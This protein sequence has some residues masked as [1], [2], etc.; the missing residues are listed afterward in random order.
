MT[1]TQY[2]YAIGRYLERGSNSVSVETSDE[3]KAMLT[4]VPPTDCMQARE[5][6]SLRLDGELSELDGV[7]LGLHLRDCTLC[8]A[9]AREIEALTLEF[10]SAP[11]EQPRGQT[12]V[13][14]PKRVPAI[15]MQAAAVAAVAVI[16]AVAGTSFAIG[17][18][19]GTESGRTTRTATSAADA[20][21]VRADSTR[22][23][24][25][26]MLRG[27]RASVSVGSGTALPL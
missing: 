4:P 11:L 3:K 10:R 23:H 24:L 21:S 18:V 19:L 27:P 14:R 13:L 5:A 15:R 17:R 9:Y 22:Q 20:A 1:L 7:R 2:S 8:R 12:F 26:A 25:L 6:A 16:A